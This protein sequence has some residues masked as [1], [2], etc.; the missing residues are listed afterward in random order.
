M[1]SHTHLATR[2]DTVVSCIFC[3]FVHKNN[4]TAGSP[5]PLT[6]VHNSHHTHRRQ[7]L[8]TTINDRY[9]HSPGPYRGHVRLGPHTFRR[10]CPDSTRRSPRERSTHPRRSARRICL[11]HSNYDGRIICRRRRCSTH[12][13]GTC[14]RLGIGTRGT[15]QGNAHVSTGHGC[16]RTYRR[17][18]QQYRHRSPDDAYSHKHGHSSR[19]SKLA[20][21]HAAGLCRKSRRNAHPYR[22]PPKPC[23]R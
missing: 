13:F 4:S 10:C 22:Y 7:P 21:A 9:T 1:L 20:S 18:C 15:R 23:Y 3:N 17:I 5:N 16:Y 11:T 8:T 2:A 12:R 19:V 6:M 14:R